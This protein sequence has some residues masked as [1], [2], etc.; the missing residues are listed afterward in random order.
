MPEVIPEPPKLTSKFIICSLALIA[1]A[2]ILVYAN[3]LQG[4]FLWDDETLIQY[5]PYIKDWSH[6]P[7]ILTSRLGSVAKEAGAFY[8][9]VQTVTYLV[10]YS[11]WKLNVFGFHTVNMVWHILAAFSVFGLIQILFRDGKLSL[12]TTLLFVTHPLHTEAV[13]YVSGRADSL[14]TFF[15]LSSFILYLKHGEKRNFL[16]LAAIAVTYMLSLLSKEYSL[17]LPGLIWFYHYSFKKPVDRKA[18]SALIG[19]LIIYGL[20]RVTVV[21]FASVAEGEIPTFFQRLPGV[22][23]AMTNYFGLLVLPLDLHM[24]HGG[25]LFPYTEPKAIVG[26][27]LVT[28]LIITVFRRKEQGRFLFF[29]V[30]WFFIALLPS[31]NL[32]F[33]INAYMAEHWLY[34]PLI[35]FNLIVARY[36][37]GLAQNQKLKGIA[38]MAM[39]GLLCFYSVLT[40]RQNTYWNNG[41]N[42]YQRMLH[43]AP[44]SSRLYNNLAKA[45]HDAGKND[46]LIKILKSAIQL[47]PTNALAHNNL[48]NAYK[49][50]GKI[51]EAVA[52]YKQAIAID[53]MHAG[54]YYN[55]SAIYADNF[56]KKDEAIQMLKKAI[57]ISPYFPKSYN[58]LG[59]LYLERGEKDKAI[60][61]LNKALKLNPDDP[62]IYHNLAYIYM[63]AGNAHDAKKMYKKAIEVNP[64]YATAYHDLAV[65]YF[66]EKN[67]RLA[68]KYCDRAVALGH[69]N[70]Q[71]V[72]YLKPYR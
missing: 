18:F 68:I 71:L 39:I 53:P 57:E 16:M 29:S 7:K 64:N 37:I 40:I 28:L 56:D 54:P 2:G 32:F 61:L 69:V 24:E 62:E 67:F 66:N 51:D 60:T 58:K 33:P 30:G 27:I 44:N 46:E 15:M 4:Q 22:F 43:Y 6:L 19:T 42:F 41:I 72:E 14:V 13:S 9:P 50:I 70:E 59:L 8:R 5:N 21:G 52:S 63:S 45:Y 65:I 25:I 11:F 36:L 55:L 1:C 47:Q 23:V 17:I 38:I 3:S 34:V 26:V 48:G 10:D 20:W 35:G 31:S 49:G 12:L